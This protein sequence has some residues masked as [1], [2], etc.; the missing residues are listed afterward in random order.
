MHGFGDKSKKSSIRETAW[1]AAKKQR[2]FL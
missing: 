1:N 2:R